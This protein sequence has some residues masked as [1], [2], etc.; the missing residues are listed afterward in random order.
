MLANTMDFEF[1]FVKIKCIVL[2]HLSTPADD[3]VGTKDDVYSHA[4]KI[5]S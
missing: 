5:K 2:V 1:S 4:A 3:V